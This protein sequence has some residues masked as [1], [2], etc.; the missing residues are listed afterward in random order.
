MTVVVNKATDKMHKQE[1]GKTQFHTA[2]GVSYH[3][4]PD[5]L[6]LT[7][8]EQLSTPQKCGRCFDD[9]GGH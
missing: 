6:Q 4:D 2:C 8:L 9:G 3:M 1:T 5:Q 7:S